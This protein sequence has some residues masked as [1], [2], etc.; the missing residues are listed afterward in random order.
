[1]NTMRRKP[2]AVALLVGASVIVSTAAP[3]LAH[4]SYAMFNRRLDLP[5]EGVVKQWQ[6]T[7]PHSYL[8]VYAPPPGDPTAAPVV[9][10]FESGSP[11]GL[12]RKGIRRDTMKP[13]DKVSLV[14]HP[15]HSGRPGGEL[16]IVTLPDG[17]VFDIRQ[18]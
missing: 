18:Y 14:V 17:R 6:L 13:G 16:K 4:H 8:E 10:T 11:A 2:V 15:L 1:M 12:I 3:A 5:M 7:N 9:W